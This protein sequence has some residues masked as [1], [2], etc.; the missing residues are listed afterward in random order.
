MV[1]MGFKYTKSLYLSVQVP[2]SRSLHLNVSLSL[3][4]REQ[5]ERVCEIDLKGENESAVFLNK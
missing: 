5:E 4:R 3:R 2:L 1:Q